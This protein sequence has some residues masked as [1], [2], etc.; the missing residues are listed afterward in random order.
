LC[1][2]HCSGTIPEKFTTANSLFLDILIH[3]GGCLVHC[4][5]RSRGSWISFLPITQKCGFSL[6]SLRLIIGKMGIRVLSSQSCF[7][8]IEV[9]GKPQW[10]RSL[11]LLSSLS[12]SRDGSDI[13]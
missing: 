8:E 3:S 12:G 1:V 9:L 4:R 10:L 2:W 6:A 11:P 13:S 5:G 7:G